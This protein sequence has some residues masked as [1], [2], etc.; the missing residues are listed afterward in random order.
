M[1]QKITD[2]DLKEG[3]KNLGKGS[4]FDE[5]MREREEEKKRRAEEL[6]KVRIAMEEAA[7][8]EGG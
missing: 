3:M 8:K 5:K 6:E 2:D 1:S 7:K 4:D